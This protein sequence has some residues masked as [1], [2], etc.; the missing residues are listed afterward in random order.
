[1]KIK[2]RRKNGGNNLLLFGGIGVAAFL[3][4]EWFKNQTSLVSI[5]PL[6]SNTTIAAASSTT[7]ATNPFNKYIISG[8]DLTAIYSV[9]VQQLG[10]TGSTASFSW[11]AKAFYYYKGF[12]IPITYPDDSVQLTVAEFANYVNNWA[13]GQGLSGLGVIGQ[14]FGPPTN[15]VAAGYFPLLNALS[16]S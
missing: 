15:N 6:T 13:S 4:Y 5:A 11:W 7:S 12:Q 9:A 14:N 8:N 10:I 1:M 2:V 16:R 3:A